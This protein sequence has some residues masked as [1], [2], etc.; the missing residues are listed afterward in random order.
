MRKPSMLM[1][2]CALTLTLVGCN[3]SNQNET[4]EADTKPAESKTEQRTETPA[5]VP[6]NT[7]DEVVEETPTAEAEPP[8]EDKPAEEETA[9]EPETEEAP[10]VEAQPEEEPAQTP[11]EPLEQ[12]GMANVKL[13]TLIL[14]NK[15]VALSADY[16]P[17]D[18]VTAN[19]DFVDTATGERKMLRKEAAQAIEKL[20][21]G[22]KTAGID[23]KGTSA[24]RS[25]EYQVQLFNNYVAKDGK[26]QAMKYSAP[27]G[28]SEHQTGLAI[29]VSSASV[30]Y[31]LTQSLEQTKEGKWL[32]DNA[33]TYGFIVRYQRAFEKE[34]GYM[35][36]PW[37][38]RYIGVEHATNVHK[39]NV[40]Y[41]RYLK[42]LMD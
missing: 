8:A 36:E 6:K 15:Q 7:E 29:D 22:A 39:T 12:N 35:Y 20:M 38:L 34:T 28:H 25:Y 26:E 3:T 18:L 1:V 2:C 17:S 40:P 21:A 9:D 41:E 32:A 19:I 10:V 31:Q 11:S 33:H 4:E 14:V 16:K 30:G 5:D 13:D 23:L 42:Q 27:P 37:H 24:F